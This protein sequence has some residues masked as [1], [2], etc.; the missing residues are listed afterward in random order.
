ML[1]VAGPVVAEWHRGSQAIMGTNV[2]VLL[3]HPDA[4]AA[5]RAI[6]QVMDEMR[7]IDSLYSPY[8]P[9][10]DLSRVNQL[11]PKASAGEPVRISDEM[12]LLLE[13]SLKYGR[14]SDGAFDITYASLGRH[15][16]YR[17]AESPTRA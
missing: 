5:T 16:D 13:A 4:T 7:R 14:L 9:E 17:A 2:D 8:R 15:Y 6:E 12:A 11:A 3:W 1:L 10:S